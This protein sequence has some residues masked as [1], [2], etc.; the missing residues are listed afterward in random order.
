[1]VLIHHLSP[2]LGTVVQSVYCTT[3]CGGPKLGQL[4]GETEFQPLHLAHH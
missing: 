3:I 1:M 2:W 4:A